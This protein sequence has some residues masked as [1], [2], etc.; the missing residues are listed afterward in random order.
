MKESPLIPRTVT[1]RTVFAAVEE[2]LQLEPKKLSSSPALTN[3][4]KELLDKAL[5]GVDKEQLGETLKKYLEDK[6]L[7]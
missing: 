1:R 7:E 6:D 4:C 3:Y 5:A 2:E